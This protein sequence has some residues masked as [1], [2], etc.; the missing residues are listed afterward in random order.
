MAG[1]PTTLGDIYKRCCRV[2]AKP[3]WANTLRDNKGGGEGKRRGKAGVEGEN[4]WGRWGRKSG[5]ER[6][7]GETGGKRSESD[8]PD[9]MSRLATKGGRR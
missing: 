6:E 7:K 4:R 1:R 2:G 9:N 5:N 8:E 3:L